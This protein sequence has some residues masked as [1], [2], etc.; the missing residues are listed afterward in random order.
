L[1]AVAKQIQWNFPERY[2]ERRF[3]IMFRGLHIEMA[4]QKAIGG[5]LEGSGW[6]AA[7]TEANVASAGPA[8]SFLKA[9]SVTHT[10][11]AHQVTAS[12]LY[13]LLTKSYT[14]YK[15]SL[16]P[17]ADVV[18]FSD[19]CLKKVASFPQFHV[20]Y[21][22]LQLEL[23]LL[24]FVRS[25]QEANFELYIEALSKMVPWFFSLDH[26]NYARWLPIHLRYMNCLNDVAPDVAVQFQQGK[27]AVS[28]TSNPFSAIPIDQAH[29]QNNALVKGEGGAVGLTVEAS[30]VT[31]CTETGQSAKHHEDTR[32]L[33]SLF[34]RDVV[35]LTT[36][37]EEMGN[38]FMEETDNLFALDTKQI[39]SLDALV[40][41]RKG[42]EVGM[43]QYESFIAERL[44]Q[45]SKSLC[46]PIK[47]NNLRVFNDPASNVASKTKQQLSSVRNDCL[48]F[49][50]L[51]ISCQMREGIWMSFSSMKTK[52]VH[53]RCHRMVSCAYFRKSR[54]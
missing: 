8:D 16:E 32:S 1:Y 28:K 42:E 7:L 11:R 54:N 52:V 12:S 38:P 31:E 53:Q 17:E 45:E 6:E 27:F 34:Y 13:V 44:M 25:F 24:A 49:S 46:T 50:R 26:T 15:E 22:T 5:W 36:T 40:R 3:V 18:S 10:R 30:M 47:R 39:M 14:S 23:L 29:E 41:L 33:Q 9:T 19:W 21:L 48:L 37:I 2:G 43:A 20:W 4:F 35:S 51:Y